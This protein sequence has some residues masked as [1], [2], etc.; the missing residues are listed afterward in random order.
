MDD[1]DGGLMFWQQFQQ[2]FAEVFENDNT[3]QA[4]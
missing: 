1:D 3:N 2:Q 4:A